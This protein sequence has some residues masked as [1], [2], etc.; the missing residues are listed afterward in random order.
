MLRH[1]A[2]TKEIRKLAKMPSDFKFT[3]HHIRNLFATW[4]HNTGQVFEGLFLFCLPLHALQ[5]KPFT[6]HGRHGNR[7]ES[8][9]RDPS[10]IL[11]WRNK[12]GFLLHTFRTLT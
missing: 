5:K 7:H 1:D 6:E 8:Q 4:G 10:R 12:V 2:A 3:A 11:S 9:Q